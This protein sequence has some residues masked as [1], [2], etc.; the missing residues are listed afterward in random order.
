MA[1]LGPQSTGGQPG[2]AVN[3]WPTWA[4]SQLVANLG[5]QATDGQPGPAVNWWPTWGR[6]QLVASLGPVSIKICVVSVIARPLDRNRKPRLARRGGSPLPYV[7]GNKAK[8]FCDVYGMDS[9]NS[10][11]QV[12]T[13]G[14]A[15]ELELNNNSL[16]FDC[17]KY[18]SSPYSNLSSPGNGV[19]KTNHFFPTFLK[20]DISITDG[21]K[22]S[23]FQQRI[24]PT[25]D[26]PTSPLCLARNNDKPALSPLEHLHF[27]SLPSDHSPILPQPDTPPSTTAMFLRGF[28]GGRSLYYNTAKV[29]RCHECGKTFKRSSTLNTHLLIH[30]DTRPYPCS[31][32]GKRFHQKSD[33]KKHTYIHTGEKPHRCQVC[34]KRFSQSSNLITHSRKHTGYTPFRCDMC[35]RTFQRKL[36]LRKHKETGKCVATL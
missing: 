34:D 26:I 1:N 5:P 7:A 36:E 28:Y 18:S 15:G 29:F 35:S 22:Q 27:P 25:L 14:N 24:A 10:T 2:A 20:P 16:K 9:F 12:N 11:L 33:M 30:S 32:C 13:E 21:T 3:W 19:S 4:R 8:S 23:F 6:S 17:N 31:Y